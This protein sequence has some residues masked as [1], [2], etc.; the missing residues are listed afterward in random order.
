MVPLNPPPPAKKYLLFHFVVGRATSN[1][2]VDCGMFLR[3]PITLQYSGTGFAAGTIVAEAMAVSFKVNFARL[4]QLAA[5]KDAALNNIQQ[6]TV[7]RQRIRRFGRLRVPTAVPPSIRIG[8]LPADSKG[9][10]EISRTNVHGAR[11]KP[12]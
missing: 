6:R 8:L 10:R 5:C 12:S 3:L 11:T 2:M 1:S 9:T 7:A 4:S